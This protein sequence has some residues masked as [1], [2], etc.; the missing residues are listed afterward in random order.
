MFAQTFILPGVVS[1]LSEE[2]LHNGSETPGARFL[3]RGEAFGGKMVQNKHI[4]CVGSGK[5][6]RRN[7][8]KGEKYVE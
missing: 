6:E 3:P 7:E 4:I 8:T 2:R 1:F 5:R